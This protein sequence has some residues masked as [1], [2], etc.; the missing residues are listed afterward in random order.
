MSAIVD[1]GDGTDTASFAYVTGT[2]T[3]DLS[4]VTTNPLKESNATSTTTADSLVSTYALIDIE[5]LGGSNNA[6]KLTGD[7]NDNVLDGGAGDDVLTGNAGDDRMIGGDGYDIVAFAANGGTGAYVDLAA[8]DASGNAVGTW[9]DAFGFRDVVDRATVEAYRGTPAADY[10]LGDGGNGTN[11][12]FAADFYGMDGDDFL[13]GSGLGQTLDGG[14]GNDQLNGLG[15][16]DTLLGGDGYDLFASTPADLDGDVI[17]DFTANDVLRVLNPGTFPSSYPF[18]LDVVESNTT[19]TILA[20]TEADGT[21]VLARVTLEGDLDGRFATTTDSAY[22]DITYTSA[23]P[24]TGTDD[25]DEL[26]GTDDRDTIL[27]YAGDDTAFR[28]RGRRQDLRRRRR[29]RAA[30]RPGRRPDPWRQRQ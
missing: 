12:L 15:G 14:D 2:V 16:A 20:I 11:P 19:Q 27:L 28:P 24:I 13:A 18:G 7:G 17:M 23:P 1:G 25:D 30:R 10:M 21:T 29:R 5:N 9:I 22:T 26:I 6:D 8:E 3:A 4:I